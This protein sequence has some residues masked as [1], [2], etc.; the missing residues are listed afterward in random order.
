MPTPPSPPLSLTLTFIVHITPACHPA[1]GSRGE[2]LRGWGQSDQLD[3]AGDVHGFPELQQGDVKPLLGD[4]LLAVHD[5][6]ADP[7]QLVP[8]IEVLLP[9]LHPQV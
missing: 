2:G 3:L 6:A 1:R 9:Q 4:I 8:V 7:E 5:D